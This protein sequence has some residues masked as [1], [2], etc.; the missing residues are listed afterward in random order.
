MWECICLKQRREAH[1][2]R[3]DR[4]WFRGFASAGEGKWFEG[5]EGGRGV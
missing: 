2:L 3:R 4:M 1:R 5:G